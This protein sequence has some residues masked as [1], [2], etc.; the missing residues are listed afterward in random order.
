MRATHSS[1]KALCC[2]RP[3]K[4]TAFPDKTVIDPA[5]KT[6][7]VAHAYLRQ[8]SLRGTLEYRGRL[9]DDFRQ[10]IIYA[11]HANVQ[12]RKREKDEF[13]PLVWQTGGHCGLTP[14]S[15]P[16]SVRS[17]WITSTRAARAAGITD[18]VTAASRST[19][20]EPATGSTPGI[21]RPPRKE[22]ASWA[23]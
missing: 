2:M 22:P 19:K 23:K 20:A 3:V 10:R 1:L 5:V 13:F 11:V 12:M 17:A 16:H 7:A 4:S 8:C 6:F 21:F 15:P 9:P 14:I 18:A